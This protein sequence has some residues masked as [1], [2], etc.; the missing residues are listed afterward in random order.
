MSVNFKLI[1]QRI[2][3]QRKKLHKTQENLAEYLDVSVGYVSLIER[4]KTKISLSTLART[5]DFLECNIGY[6]VDNIS[7]ENTNYLNLEL[8]DKIKKLNDFEK[9][10]LFKLIDTYVNTK[11]R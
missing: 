10:T 3:G 4:G 6:L 8:N 5:A 11:N 2:Q 1:G 9:E 7:T